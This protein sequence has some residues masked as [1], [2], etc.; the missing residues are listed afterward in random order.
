MQETKL[1]INLR[2]KGG[3]EYYLHVFQGTYC[4]VIDEIKSLLK[5]IFPLFKVFAS[6]LL[7][8]WAQKFY[9]LGNLPMN[10]W[11]IVSNNEL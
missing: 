4:Q 8:S 2:K 11:I 10:F 1:A 6:L 7:L 5:N 3:V 9:N